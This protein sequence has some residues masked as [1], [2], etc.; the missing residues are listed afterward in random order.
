MAATYVEISREDFE[1]WLHSL[2]KPWT[3][4][5]GKAGI[6]FVHLSDRV[7]VK[8]SSSIGSAGSAMERAAASIDLVLVSLV[9]GKTLN[10]RGAE[11][12]RYHR[13]QG[14]RDNLRRGVQHWASVYEEAREFY[15][16]IAPIA[17]RQKYKDEH[18]RVI[19]HVPGH[20]QD[21]VLARIR[22]RLVEGGVLSDP[23]EAVIKVAQGLSADQVKFLG[24]LDQLRQKA[25]NDHQTA[26]LVAQVRQQ[27]WSGHPLSDEVKRH[28][29]QAL[30]R[31]QVS[32]A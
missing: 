20:E 21:D 23:E 13:T 5:P 15:D 31:Y 3:R 24:R 29:A 16:R 18:I 28:L 25:A 7:G 4:E 6:Y 1:Q 26:I 8:I 22:K 14:W 11:Q 17:D 19:D 32:K 12:S 27:V 30:Q 9:T 10:R 2:G